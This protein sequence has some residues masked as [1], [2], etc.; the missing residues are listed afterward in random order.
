MKNVLAS[1]DE[2]EVATCFLN[3]Q[4]AYLLRTTFGE[5]CHPQPPTTSIQTDNQCA[6]GILNATVKQKRSKANDVRF[7]WLNDR[8]VQKQFL[9]YW[10][11]GILNMADYFTKHHSAV[12]HATM[13]PQYLHEPP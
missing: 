5:L 2:A 9:V 8:I 10:L 3:A 1:A 11:P 7:Y 6:A 13:R 12:H 4:E